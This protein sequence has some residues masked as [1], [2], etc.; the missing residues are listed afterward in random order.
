MGF[1]EEGYGRLERQSRP[2]WAGVPVIVGLVLVTGIALVIFLSG[3]FAARVESCRQIA[4]G[5][6]G[7]T[8]VSEQP[9]GFLQV[10]GV[11]ESVYTSP[12]GPETVQQAFNTAS[13]AIMRQAVESGDFRNTVGTTTSVTANDAGGSTVTVVCP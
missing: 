5:I 10:N 11:L 8:L 1:S 4:R 2:I 13:A 12:D 7:L 3:Q 9:M 6:P